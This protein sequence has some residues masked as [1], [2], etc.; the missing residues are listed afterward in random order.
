M[1]TYT[2][3]Q[4]NDVG[5]WHDTDKVKCIRGR[6]NGSNGYV[7]GDVIK[8]IRIPAGTVVLN[9]LSQQ[10]TPQS[11]TGTCTALTAALG[12]SSAGNNWDAAYS[13]MGTAGAVACGAAASETT[14]VLAGGYLYAAADYIAVTL[15][16]TGGGATTDLVLDVMAIVVQF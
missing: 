11:T 9:V 2:L 8:V 13:V 16:L 12:D 14:R 5:A 15:A 7:D 1:A 10:V 3:Y 6:V 4:A